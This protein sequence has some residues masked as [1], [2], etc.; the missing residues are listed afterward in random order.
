[1]ARRCRHCDRRLLP[2]SRRGD[3]WGWPVRHARC[4]LALR[5]HALERGFNWKRPAP[6]SLD[7]DGPAPVRNAPLSWWSWGSVYLHWWQYAPPWACTRPWRF[8]AMRACDGVRLS[9]TIQLPLLG[10]VIYF[11][12]RPCGHHVENEE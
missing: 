8:R 1:M 5:D 9:T 10:H 2:T 6:W 12:N 3:V 11:H 7:D 4:A